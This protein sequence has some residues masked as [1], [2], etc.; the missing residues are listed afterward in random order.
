LD[1][2]GFHMKKILETLC[3]TETNCN[4]IIYDHVPGDACSW[5]CVFKMEEDVITY[6]ICR[7]CFVIFGA[8]CCIV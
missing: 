4:V 3:Q 7:L 8:I 6:T 5:H 2:T 1:L